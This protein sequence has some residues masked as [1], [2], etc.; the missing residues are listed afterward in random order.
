MSYL[1]RVDSA[2]SAIAFLRS[3]HDHGLL[4]HPEESALESL[5]SHKLAPWAI[6][7]IERNMKRCFDYLAD[8]CETA[9]EIMA[10]CD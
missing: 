5:Q 9:L 1:D 8:P 4:Y 6:A 10:P 7:Q 2:E 3:L